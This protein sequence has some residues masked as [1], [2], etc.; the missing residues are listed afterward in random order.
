ME[1]L[2]ASVWADVLDV[3][4]IGNIGADDDFFVL[5]GHSLAATQVVGQLSDAIGVG[6]P[7][8]MLFDR[9]VLRDFAAEAER[10]ALTHLT[11]QGD[12]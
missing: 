3:L 5:G 2:V 1:R 12:R 6:I 9:P 8:G 10:F 7:V 4:R 11:D